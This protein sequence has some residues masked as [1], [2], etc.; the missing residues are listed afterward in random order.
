MSG[1]H[2]KITT[3]EEE[4]HAQIDVSFCEIRS[5]KIVNKLFWP[6]ELSTI[7]PLMHYIRR[8][9]LLPDRGIVVYGVSGMGRVIMLPP[10]PAPNARTRQQYYVEIKF[11]I[12]SY[13]SSSSVHPEFTDLASTGLPWRWPTG[14]ARWS[15]QPIA[16]C[17]MCLSATQQQRTIIGL[18]YFQ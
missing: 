17:R 1:Y 5:Q 7:N 9:T 2:N 12:L 10:P 8:C 3:T 16:T 4:D 11:F 14:T 13:N 18:L 15:H 6:G